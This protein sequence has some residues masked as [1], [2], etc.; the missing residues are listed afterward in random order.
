MQRREPRKAYEVWLVRDPQRKFTVE[1]PSVLAAR[2]LGADLLHA[3]RFDVQ[4]REKDAKPLL[5]PAKHPYVDPPWWGRNPG[6]R[7][8][9]EHERF[10]AAIPLRYRQQIEALPPQQRRREL[11]RWYWWWVHVGR[12]QAEG[13]QGQLFGDEPPPW[14]TNPDERTR[15]LERTWRQGG[16]TDDERHYL[17]ALARSGEAE[18]WQRARLNQLTGQPYEPWQTTQKSYAWGSLFLTACE[19]W[20]WDGVQPTEHGRRVEGVLE[21]GE[22]AAR[23]YV[24]PS[25]YP[26][27][28]FDYLDRVHLLERLDSAAR[29]AAEDRIHAEA[30]QEAVRDGAVPYRL[31]GIMGLYSP[32]YHLRVLVA[33]KDVRLARATPGNWAASV[34]DQI[35]YP[36]EWESVRLMTRVR[37]RWR[38]PEGA[39]CR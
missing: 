8:N 4:A 12:K 16:G 18:V 17:T 13:H 1:A 11:K 23:F 7:R 36:D 28:G 3:P 22:G 10:L 25:S 21:G 26:M 33:V 30:V 19:S 32:S 24:T 39:P 20:R 31:T 35:L 2:E 34:E 38:N 5:G 9:D 15:E 27:I 29:A 6:S 14:A 37:G